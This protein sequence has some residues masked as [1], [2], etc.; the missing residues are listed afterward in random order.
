MSISA[1]PGERGAV[2]V[3]GASSG[4]GMACAQALVEAGFDVFAGIR[5]PADGRAL[6]AELAH[7]PAG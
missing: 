2:V 3:T 5:K 7:A 1:Q 4:I 6:E